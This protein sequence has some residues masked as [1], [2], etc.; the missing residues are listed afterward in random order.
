[1]SAHE[2]NGGEVESIL[3][4]DA[5]VAQERLGSGFEFF[6]FRSSLISTVDVFV[7]D[8]FILIDFGPVLFEPK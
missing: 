3:A 5:V 6:E 4:L 7:D 1:M 8:G 2:V